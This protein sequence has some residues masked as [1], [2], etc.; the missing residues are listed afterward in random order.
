MESQELWG[1]GAW[2]TTTKLF[3]T[4]AG[5]VPLDKG[6]LNIFME[7]KLVPFGELN[8]ISQRLSH[9]FIAWDAK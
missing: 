4:N 2:P 3:H 1:H 9:N 5:Q 6:W 8:Q 7:I